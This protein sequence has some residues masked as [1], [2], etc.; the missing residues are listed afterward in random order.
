[1]TR[2]RDKAILDWKKT[3]D[4]RM[5]G[6]I[7]AK[8]RRILEPLSEEQQQVF[9]SLV[10]E[11]VDTVLHHLLWTLEQEDNVRIGIL[12][13]NEDVNNLK[14]ISDGLAGELYSGE[15]WIAR[16]SKEKV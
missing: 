5:K 12:A 7:A 1:M 2:V 10:P 8:I 4:G 16:F 13:D 9:L 11:V 6:E 14:D 3:V 15:G